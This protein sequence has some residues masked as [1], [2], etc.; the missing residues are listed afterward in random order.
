MFTKRK[1]AISPLKN[2]T[3]NTIN[4]LYNKNVFT[5]K[6]SQKCDHKIVI[7]KMCSQKNNTTKYFL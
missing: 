4:S 1:T 6:L 7:T 3:D 5:K 2:T